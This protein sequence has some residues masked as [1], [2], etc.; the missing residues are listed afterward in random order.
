LLLKWCSPA[1]GEFHRS[2]P[3]DD[4]GKTMLRRYAI[5]AMLV[6]VISS[7]VVSA[8]RR[9]SVFAQQSAVGHLSAEQRRAIQLLISS[10]GSSSDFFSSG[11]IVEKTSFEVG[12]PIDIRIIVTNTGREPVWVCAFSN[13][14]YQ[15]RPQLTRDGEVVAYSEKLRELIRQSDSGMLCEFTRTP[16]VVNLKP[17]ARLRVPGIELQEWYAPLSPGHYKLFLKRTFACCADGQWN[18][19]NAISFDVTR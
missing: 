16:D 17:N 11:L 7:F 8:V 12:E 6:A 5:A 13:P 3:L 1:P 2:T 19:T 14:Y 9:P 18:S 10:N 4:F 15:N